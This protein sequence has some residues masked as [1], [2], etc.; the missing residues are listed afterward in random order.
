VM[1]FLHRF[2]GQRRCTHDWGLV[3]SEHGVDE[4]GFPY[5]DAVFVCTH[6]EERGFHYASAFRQG[7]GALCYLG[8]WDYTEDIKRL[9]KRGE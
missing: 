4:Y 6:C 7:S 9:E 5:W 2:F 3:E 1:G 8:N